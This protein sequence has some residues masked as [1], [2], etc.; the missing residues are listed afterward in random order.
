MIDKAVTDF[1]EPDSPT[2][3]SVSPRAMS[4]DTLSTTKFS[5][6]PCENEIERS[7]M[8]RSGAVVAS[9]VLSKCLARIEGVAHR[10]ADE[11]QKRKHDRDGEKAGEAEPRRL[12]V[13]LALRQ[14]F[15]KRR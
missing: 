14:H 8:E 6:P 10:L 1:P 11:N 15:A 12:N 7:R 9:M 2:S 5:R 13:R 4:N 3:A